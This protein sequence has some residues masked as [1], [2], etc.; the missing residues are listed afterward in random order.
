MRFRE[1]FPSG[2]ELLA[3]LIAALLVLCTARVFS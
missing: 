2:V 3:L 1:W